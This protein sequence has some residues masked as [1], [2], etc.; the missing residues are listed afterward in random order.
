MNNLTFIDLNDFTKISLIT[1]MILG[2]VEIIAVI[3]LIKRFILR[4]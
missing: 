1:F 3:Y 2:K 4:E